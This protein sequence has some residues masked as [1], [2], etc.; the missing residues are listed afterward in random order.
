MSTASAPP[1][2]SEKNQAKQNGR[3]NIAATCAP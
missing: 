1:S 2:P 3:P